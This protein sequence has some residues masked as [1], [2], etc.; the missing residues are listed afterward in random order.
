MLNLGVGLA[1]LWVAAV[2]LL[3]GFGIHPYSRDAH[4]A[5]RGTLGRLIGRARDFLTRRS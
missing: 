3:N 1:L 4:R 2:A 5:L